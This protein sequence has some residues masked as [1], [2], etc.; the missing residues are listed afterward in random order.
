MAAG[1]DII[2]AQVHLNQIGAGWQAA[3]IDSVIAT[4]IEAMD[5]VGIDRVLI[6][7]DSDQLSRTEQEWLLGRPARHLPSW[8]T[9]PRPA[10]QMNQ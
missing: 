9:E 8:T 5:A 2:D 10:E 4:A 3:S 1:I 7:A 6:G